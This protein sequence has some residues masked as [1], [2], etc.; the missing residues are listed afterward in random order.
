[1]ILKLVAAPRIE[2]F[3]Q[4]E[5]E[6]GESEAICDALTAYPGSDWVLRL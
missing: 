4:Q 1:M 6:L 3:G 5:L 2:I